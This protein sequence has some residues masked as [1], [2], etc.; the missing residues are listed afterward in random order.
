MIV[1]LAIALICFSVVLL[2]VAYIIEAKLDW[3]KEKQLLL[4]Y[5]EFEY[6]RRVSRKFVVLFTL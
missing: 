5:S 1:A 6:G 3:T 4:W 2:F